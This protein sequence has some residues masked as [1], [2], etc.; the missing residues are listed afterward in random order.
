M[1]KN[2]ELSSSAQFSKTFFCSHA[3]VQ[4]TFL[5]NAVP[6][7]L[8]RQ[9]DESARTSETANTKNRLGKIVEEA[10][11]QSCDCNRGDSH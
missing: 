10:R 6:L 2:A 4:A 8:Q 9:R 1:T 11:F 7:H 5:Q 3:T